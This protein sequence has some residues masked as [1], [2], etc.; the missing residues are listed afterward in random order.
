MWS[1]SFFCYA[2]DS[3]W[4]S[5]LS[6]RLIQQHSHSE[7][8]PLSLFIASIS[9]IFGYSWWVMLHW[10]L[11]ILRWFPHLS[12]GQKTCYRI[13]FEGWGGILCYDRCGLRV[14]L[15]IALTVDRGPLTCHPLYCMNHG[16]ARIARSKVYQVHWDWLSLLLAQM[17]P[18][19]YISSI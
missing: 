17:F 4:C 10:L 9:C 19:P 12:K 2:S 3:L 16:A 6:F 15:V 18:L 5:V 7:F 1:S 8:I 14:C 13:L 11:C